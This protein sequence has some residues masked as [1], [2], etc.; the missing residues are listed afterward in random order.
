MF[1]EELR[2]LFNLFDKQFPLGR[3]ELEFLMAFQKVDVLHDARAPVCARLG[4]A[5]DGGALEVVRLVNVAVRRENVAH[6]DKVN[7]AAVGEL[8]A[9]KAVEASEEG[10]RVVLHIL[11]EGKMSKGNKVKG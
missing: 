8:D 7:L 4:V 2:V 9:V 6:D 1:R 5:T 3:S 11:R 10:V